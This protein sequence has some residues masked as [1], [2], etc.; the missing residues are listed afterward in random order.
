MKI[1]QAQRL[2]EVKPP[3]LVK[4][5]KISS[6]FSLESQ[7]DISSMTGLDLNKELKNFLKYEIRRTRK[8]KPSN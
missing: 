4:S 8:N 5:R 1:D 7:Q 2:S 3:I 6:N